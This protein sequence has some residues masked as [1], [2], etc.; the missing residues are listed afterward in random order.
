MEISYA[1]RA[2]INDIYNGVEI[3]IPA[4]KP[5]VFIIRS[6]A[7]IGFAVVFYFFFWRRNPPMAQSPHVDLFTI[8]V[9]CLVA[10]GAVFTLYTW[11]W[12]LAGKE[13][14]TVADGVLTIEKKGAIAKTNSYDLKEAKD[15]R[16]V[17]ENAV[18]GRNK[19]FETYPWVVAN[20]GTLKFDYGV[21]TIQFGDW[22]SQTE[23]DY[24][25]ERLRNKKL[26][27]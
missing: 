3:I 20:H 5:A 4:K 9:L 23:G 22:L 2:T 24:I 10:L 16:A 21:E 1:G 26:I 19:S 18:Y 27:S 7:A 17:E 8:F 11:W 15:F 6:L 25:L 13:I 14:V 12:M